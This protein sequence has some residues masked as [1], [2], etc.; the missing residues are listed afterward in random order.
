MIESYYYCAEICVIFTE[1]KVEGESHA[2][3]M[4][5]QSLF[6]YQMLIIPQCFSSSSPS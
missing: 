6:A 4:S 5:G 2:F 3:I 1:S